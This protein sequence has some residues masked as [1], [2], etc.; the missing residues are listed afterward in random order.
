MVGGVESSSRIE[1]ITTV[2]GTEELI[3]NMGPQHPSTHGV[4]R[5]ILK[6]EGETVKDVD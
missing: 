2:P 6:L 3:V 1:R 4:L 5:V